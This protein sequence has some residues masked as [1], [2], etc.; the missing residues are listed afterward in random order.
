MLIIPEGIS[1][2]FNSTLTDETGEGIDLTGYSSVVI[3]A[4]PPTIAAISL[5]AT[6]DQI[7]PA[8]I[9]ADITPAQLVGVGD[10]KAW[11]V[12]TYSDGRVVKSNGL[13][14]R[15]VAEGTTVAP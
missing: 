4:K 13:A 14:F 12:A 6:I 1:F 9:H 15:V 10:W 7:S 11:A 3:K 2:R 5:A 8:M